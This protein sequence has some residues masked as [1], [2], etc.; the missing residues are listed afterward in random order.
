MFLRI[1]TNASNKNKTASWILIGCVNYVG[2]VINFESFWFAV[3]VALLQRDRLQPNWANSFY[4]FFRRE[5]FAFMQK[6]RSCGRP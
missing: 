4:H 3:A 6:K 5:I 1:K 2:G